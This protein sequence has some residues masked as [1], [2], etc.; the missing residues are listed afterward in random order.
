MYAKPLYL[1]DRT[2]LYHSSSLKLIP[3][4]S[5]MFIIFSAFERMQN[6]L[7]YPRPTELVDTLI[8]NFLEYI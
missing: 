6:N 8:D 7:Y 3:F 4:Y 1:E 2:L 5:E